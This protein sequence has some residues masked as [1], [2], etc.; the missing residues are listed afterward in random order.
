MAD[1]QPLAR[2][3]LSRCSVSATIGAAT[4][5]IPQ[6]T[7][8]IANGSEAVAGSENPQYAIRYPAG[9]LSLDSPSPLTSPATDP[10]LYTPSRDDFSPVQITS[11]GHAFTSPVPSGDFARVTA[12]LRRSTSLRSA[13]SP[14]HSHKARSPSSATV[15]AF[16]SETNP[17]PNHQASR[18]LFSLSTLARRRKSSDHKKSYALF[19]GSEPIRPSTAASMTTAATFR[20][21]PLSS[22]NYANGGAMN[23]AIAPQATPSF[24]APPVPVGVNPQVTYQTILDTASK[25]ISTLDYLRKA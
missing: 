18:S 12:G 16:P 11:P 21:P 13:A 3:Q 24:A 7:F 5:P 8:K 22:L 9:Q 20:G 14:G 15:I 25:R 19:S 1:L 17:Q 10:T 2:D 6:N 4:M 23:G